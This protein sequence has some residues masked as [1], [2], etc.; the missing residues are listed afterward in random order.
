MSGE[1]V[2]VCEICGKTIFGYPMTVKVA[3][4]P[5]KVCPSCA[6]NIRKERLRPS[7]RTR[8]GKALALT[9]RK[10]TKRA[11]G[12]TTRAGARP[13]TEEYELVDDYGENIRRA[14]EELGLKIEQIAESIRIKASLLRKVEAG[15]IAP[16]YE[17]AKAI[18]KLLD[19]DII[20]KKR[21][22][23]ALEVL[24]SRRE[25]YTPVTLGE[26]VRLK[27]KKE[28]RKEKE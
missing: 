23:G 8:S 5:S 3:G 22:S 6:K 9:K 19:V 16:S 17:V 21:S 7:Q 11:K 4:Y 28:K 27:E 12:P 18:E 1:R 25:D 13:R 2:Y 14:R 15:R 10:P 20:E 26:L 24:A